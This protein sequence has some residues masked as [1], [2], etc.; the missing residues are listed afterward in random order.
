MHAADTS[1]CKNKSLI[2]FQFPAPPKA[3]KGQFTPVLNS[4]KTFKS[5]PSKLPSRSILFINI[6]PAP[7]NKDSRIACF[8][9]KFELFLPL[10]LKTLYSLFIFFI[11]ML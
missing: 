7:C 10:L 11:S 5:Y 1:V 6:S 9:F 2:C 8:G 3:K 4:F